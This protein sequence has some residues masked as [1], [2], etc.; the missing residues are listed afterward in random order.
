MTGLSDRETYE[1]TH[2]SFVVNPE[3]PKVTVHSIS[4]TDTKTHKFPLLITSG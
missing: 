3:V 2:S 4:H 1:L